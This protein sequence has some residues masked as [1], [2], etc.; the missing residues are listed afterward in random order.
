M[1]S[2]LQKL[3]RRNVT[4]N[5]NK[6]DGEWVGNMELVSEDIDAG[7]L[8]RGCRIQQHSTTTCRWKEK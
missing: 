3:G 5:K 2:M 8:G 7:K 1:Q 4:E 6:A